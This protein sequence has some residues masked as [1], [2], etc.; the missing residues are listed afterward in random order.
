[1]LCSAASGALLRTNAPGRL[2]SMGAAASDPGAHP[3]PAATARARRLGKFA[4]GADG[5]RLHWDAWNAFTRTPTGPAGRPEDRRLLR[6]MGGGQREDRNTRVGGGGGGSGTGRSGA[7]R[8]G[9]TDNRGAWARR[10]R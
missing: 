2:A 8:D 6:R 3:G 9:R 7:A 5:R 1:M 4:L 10:A